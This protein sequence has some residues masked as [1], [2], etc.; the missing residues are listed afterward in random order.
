MKLFHIP[1]LKKKRLYLTYIIQKYYAAFEIIPAKEKQKAFKI[2]KMYLTVSIY[3]LF[4][5]PLT[6]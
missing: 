2:L 3:V 6:V 1:R 5:P 4:I